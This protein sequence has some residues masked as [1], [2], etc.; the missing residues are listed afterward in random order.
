[1]GKYSGRI[2]VAESEFCHSETFFVKANPWEVESR[3]APLIASKL[4]ISFP[5]KKGKVYS[6]L[7]E[8]SAFYLFEYSRIS[9]VKGT[10]TF[11]VHRPNSHARS[12]LVQPFRN[13]KKTFDPA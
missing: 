12:S 5:R 10:Q 1:M 9:F 11:C 6:Q 4:K 7:K 13:I 3:R 2:V 8:Q